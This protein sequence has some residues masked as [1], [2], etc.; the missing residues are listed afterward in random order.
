MIPSLIYYFYFLF[1]KKIIFCKKIIIIFTLNVTDVTLST[2]VAYTN[3]FLYIFTTCYSGIYIFALVS[4]FFLHDIN[5]NSTNP[6][7]ISSPIQVQNFLFLF[8]NRQKLSST[9][10]STPSSLF[11]FYMYTNTVYNI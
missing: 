8:L 5:S 9:P 6:Y 11:S 1:N 2:F 3:Y 7:L 4:V 10:S